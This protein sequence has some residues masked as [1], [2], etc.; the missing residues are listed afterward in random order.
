MSICKRY[1][2]NMYKI[3][4][5]ETYGSHRSPEK[6]FKSIKTFVQ[7]YMNEYIITFYLSRERKD[8]LSSVRI[9]GHYLFKVEYVVP[10]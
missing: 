6:Y 4:K 1:Q 3:N 9:N 7:S 10:S 5:Q 8:I 2:I